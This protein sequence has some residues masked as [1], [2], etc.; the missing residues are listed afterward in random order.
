MESPAG[1]L[2][3]VRIP[4]GLLNVTDP[5]SHQVVHEE[6]PRTGLVA[7][8][9]TEGFR[10]HLLSLQS[11]GGAWS[12]VD[13]FPREAQ[14]AL[15]SFPLF[16]WPGWEEPTYHLKLKESYGIL[17]EALKDIPEHDDAN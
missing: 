3:E 17:K 2:I 16:R 12:V 7:T 14:P 11:K 9:R 10:F 1:D 5:S 15:A 8:R 6:A 4:W 13:R